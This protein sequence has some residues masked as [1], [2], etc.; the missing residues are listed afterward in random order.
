MTTYLGKG[1][2]FGLP[3]VP[4]V[5]CHQFMYLVISLLVLRAGCGIWLYQF[6]IIAY[7]FTLQ[8][9]IWSLTQTNQNYT[10]KC[11][12]QRRYTEIKSISQL[13]VIKTR[14]KMTNGNNEAKQKR[15]PPS[16]TLKGHG[17]VR[18]K[19]RFAVQDNIRFGYIDNSLENRFLILNR[20]TDWRARLG[21]RKTGLRPPHPPPPRILILTVP[22]RYFCCGSL[23]L[24]VLAVRIYTL[25]HLLCEWHI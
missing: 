5:N 13:A 18:R 21:T 3:R 22:R 8:P 16:C 12:K 17:N 24:L 6:L 25:V 19:P 9:T 11:C 4:F 1:C 2:S 7:L 15:L 14:G 10:Q 23:L 20:L